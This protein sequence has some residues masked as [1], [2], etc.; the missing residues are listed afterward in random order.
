MIFYK[1]IINI[2]VHKYTRFGTYSQHRNCWR[3]YVS[4]FLP[5]ITG[6]GTFILTPHIF[7]VFSLKN[8]KIKC[9]KTPLYG[10]FGPFLFLFYFF[11]RPPIYYDP[12]HLWIFEKY[13]APLITVLRVI[14]VLQAWDHCDSISEYI[15]TLFYRQL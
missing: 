5:K 10:Y 13:L 6:L 9:L 2:N 3:G 1:R 14:H 8:L 4:V 7:W 15:D 12:I 11:F